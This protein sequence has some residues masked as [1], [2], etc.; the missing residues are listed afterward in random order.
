MTASP[1][2][3]CCAL[4]PP[5]TPKKPPTFSGGGFL[6]VSGSFLRPSPVAVR[7]R[8]NNEERDDDREVEPAHR[9][10]YT[11]S[12]ARSQINSPYPIIRTKHGPAANRAAAA[13]LFVT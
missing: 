4:P 13:Q 11:A 12:G 2:A 9:A 10:H 1:V 6:K 5:C 3:G 7:D 8:K